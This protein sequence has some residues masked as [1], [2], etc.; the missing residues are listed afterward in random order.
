[1]NIQDIPLNIIWLL[2]QQPP[3]IPEVKYETSAKYF[4]WTS[5]AHQIFLWDPP[6]LL[7]AGKPTKFSLGTPL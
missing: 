2:A 4:I 1:M 6:F 3:A 7:H 5:G